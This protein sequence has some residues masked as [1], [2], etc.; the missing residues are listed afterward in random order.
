MTK[1]AQITKNQHKVPSFYLQGFADGANNVK[2]LDLSTGRI[3][4]PRHYRSVGYERFFY[5]VK[6]GVPD[7]ISQAFEQWFGSLENQIAERMPDIISNAYAGTLRNS[8]FDTLA[9][10]IALQWMRTDAFRNM[11]NR[12]GESMYKGVLQVSSG[13]PSFSDHIREIAAEEGRDVTDE[14]IAQH[15]T[16]FQQGNYRLEFDNSMH[17][18]FIGPTQLEGFHNML[19]AQ[20]WTVV[21]VKR[22]HRFI[23]SDNP[24]AV[25]LPKAQGM[26]GRSFMERTHCLPLTPELLIETSEPNPWPEPD[27]INPEKMASYRTVVDDSEVLAYNV[28]NVRR[29][30]RFVYARARRD[31]HPQV[32]GLSGCRRAAR[33]GVQLRRA[34]RE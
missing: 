9:Y 21:R 3:L 10:L 17:L 26:F 14:E 5:A 7:E 25:A 32:P 13:F 2:S 16:F 29:A 24:V 19:L 18:K 8:Q 11:V 12:L 30:H 6:T 4:K 23:T 27:Q 1:K 33:R 34:R 22:D 20:Q 15:R 31:L 28:L